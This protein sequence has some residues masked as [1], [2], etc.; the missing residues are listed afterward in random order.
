M[1]TLVWQ[2]PQHEMVAGRPI[3]T[4]DVDAGQ[5][6]NQGAGVKRYSSRALLIR[7][8]AWP[9]ASTVDYT[10]T[11]GFLSRHVGRLVRRY[12]TAGSTF[13][14]VG[15]G[16]MR[17]RRHLPQGVTYNG[18]DLQLSE[19][20]VGRVGPSVNIAVASATAIPLPD[21]CVDVAA[22]AEVLEHVPDVDGALSEIHR[23]L[24]PGG[25]LLGS[26]PNNHCRKY[27]TKGPHPGHI[28]NWTYDGFVEHC[29]GHG[30]ELV[31]GY[32]IGW[33]LPIPTWITRRSIQLPLSLP[34]EVDNTNFIFALRRRA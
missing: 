22:A 4:A 29:H 9:L 26:I 10:L 17:L 20:H 24:Q 18:F 32:M 27:L 25:M 11:D 31:E 21:S 15:C 13:L 28:H 16:D 6:H 14:D 19:F 30:F 34:R 2:L 8:L 33:W 23:I 1:T 7:R 12:A 5:G 3:P